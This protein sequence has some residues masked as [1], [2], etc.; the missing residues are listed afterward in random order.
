MP[1]ITLNPRH[2]LK[3]IHIH[4]VRIQVSHPPTSINS[5]K[6]EHLPEGDITDSHKISFEKHQP[7]KFSKNYYI[8][9]IP[10][11]K[12]NNFRKFEKY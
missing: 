11:T 2:A 7:N 1:N 3:E 10:K 5:F 6:G 9:L 4:R 8:K 12:P